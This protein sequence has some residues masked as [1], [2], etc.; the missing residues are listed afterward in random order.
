M[1]ASITPL[2][3]RGRQ[4]RWT[5]TVGAFVIGGVAGGAALG[6]LA[7]GLGGIALPGSLGAPARLGV[8]A[9]L[10]LLALAVD[11]RA[12]PAP[13]PRRQVNEHWLHRYRGWV[14]GF[15]FGAQL[16]FGLATVV[17]SAATYVALAAAFLTGSPADGGLIVGCFGLVRGLTPLAGARIDRLE[18]LVAFHA[19]LD[20]ARTAAVRAGAGGLAAILVVAVAGA[21]S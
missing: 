8:L 19:R 16:G 15:G 13:G 2:G 14:Y 6:A 10:A 18:R 21:A 1:L 5:V 7:G 4:S 17:S 11:A 12:D 9:L 3:E 20:R